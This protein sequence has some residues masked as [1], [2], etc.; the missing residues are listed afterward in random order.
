MKLEEMLYTF[1]AKDGTLIG[2][3]HMRFDDAV[4]LVDI[5]ENMGAD[6]RY[7]R[8][9]QSIDHVNAGRIWQEAETIAHMD[10]KKQAGLIAF[11]DLPDKPNAPVG[12]A[13]YICIGDGRA[14]TGIS[15]RDDM[16][17]Q[18]IGTELLALL[19][20]EA[21]E[22]GIQKLVADVLNS[23]KG[24]MGILQKLPYEMTRQPE[25]VYSTLT[26]HWDRLKEGERRRETAVTSGR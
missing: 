7:Q 15:V 9:H 8:Y 11:A 3:R 23:N 20:E 6:S 10:A 14:D 19:V 18:G 2:V 5:F 17:G 12:A 24:I 13:R 22:N 4:Y 21:R 1:F 16:Q 26:I 25:G